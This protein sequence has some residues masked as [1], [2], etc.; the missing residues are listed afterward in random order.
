MQGF[1][2]VDGAIEEADLA[3]A[4]RHT[5]ALSERNYAWEGPE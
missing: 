4:C 3:P 1:D 5:I 2:L